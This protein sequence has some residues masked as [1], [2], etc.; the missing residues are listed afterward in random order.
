MA[1]DRVVQERMDAEQ[2]QLVMPFY[3]ICDVSFSMYREMGALNEGVRRLRQAIVSEPVVDDVAQVCIMTFSDKAK[4]IVPMG[5][6]S[7]SEVPE[8]TAENATNYGLAFRALAEA[9]EK[10]SANFRDKG[11][12]VYR[13]CAFF[14]TDGLP[15]DQDWYK[16]F[17]STLTYDVETGRGMKAHPIFVPFG[18]RDAH[19]EVLGQLAYPPGRSAW[20]HA[21]D[22]GIELVLKGVLG[23][24]KNTV[25]TSSRSASTG[26][27]M[28]VQQPPEPDSPIVQGTSTYRSDYDPDYIQ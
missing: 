15:T 23:I 27:P 3:L 19:E 24:I 17:A 20:Y 11:L 8:L 10:D 5:P 6:M 2:G 14:L 22:T 12:R 18:F 13:P 28:I 1:K 4:I 16:T 26:Q 25:I 21:K 7:E 9:I